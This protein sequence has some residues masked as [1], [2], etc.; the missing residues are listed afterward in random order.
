MAVRTRGYR[1]GWNK[2]HRPYIDV[3]GI[4]ELKYAVD[5]YLQADNMLVSTAVF[6]VSMMFKKETR[7]ANVRAFPSITGRYMRSV[8]FAKGKSARATSSRLYAGNLSAI[9]EYNGAVIDAQ[10]DTAFGVMSNRRTNERFP[11]YATKWPTFVSRG[12]F[13]IERRP[14]FYPAVREAIWQRKPE[15]TVIETIDKYYKEGKLIPKEMGPR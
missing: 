13:H 8:Y 4:H 15:S 2:E 3:S 1:T 12:V 9:Y 10:S 5:N 14:W 7:D 11:I 6:D